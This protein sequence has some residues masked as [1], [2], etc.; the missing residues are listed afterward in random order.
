MTLNIGNEL[1][2][3]LLGHLGGPTAISWVFAGTKI[4]KARGPER[5][6][7]HGIRLITPKHPKYEYTTQEYPK[8]TEFDYTVITISIVLYVIFGNKPNLIRAQL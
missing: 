2:L 8:R 5:L 4:S 7:K 1:A 3:F 6:R